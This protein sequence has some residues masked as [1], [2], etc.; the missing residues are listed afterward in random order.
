MPK[1]R[2]PIAKARASGAEIKNAGRFK[3]RG[4]PKVSALGKPSI[5]LSGG[6]LVAWESF[7]RELPWLTEADRSLL[8]VACTIRGRLIDGEDVGIAPMN[9]LRMCLGQMGATPADRSKVPVDDGEEE[10]ADSAFFQ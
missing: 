9:T 7:S 6:A 10:D 1:P 2:L 3:G 8:E 4:N 5:F